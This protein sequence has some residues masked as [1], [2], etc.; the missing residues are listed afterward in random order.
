MATANKSELLRKTFT[1]E[2]WQKLEA[3]LRSG[4]EQGQPDKRWQE[5][6][7]AI[8]FSPVELLCITGAMESFAVGRY[9]L[10]RGKHDSDQVWVSAV[11]D[12][13]GSV[14]IS[15][16][17]AFTE[18]VSLLD[19]LL[20][21]DGASAPLD[22]SFEIDA[23]EL[24]ILFAFAD[25]LKAQQ[26]Q[27]LLHRE[28]YKVS[29]VT[30]EQ[31]GDSM[32]Q[33]LHVQDFRWW[34]TT[35]AVLSPFPLNMDAPTAREAVERLCQKKLLKHSGAGFLPDG[36]GNFVG[37][38]LM[39]LSAASLSLM[40]RTADGMPCGIDNVIAIRT[41]TAFW[42]LN[43]IPSPAGPAIHV[44]SSPAMLLLS[45]ID[46]LVECYKQEV[47]SQHAGKG[48]EALTQKTQ[49]RQ[50]TPDA[51]DSI[52]CPTC[53]KTLN[54]DVKFCSYCGHKMEATP[55]PKAVANSSSR[56]DFEKMAIRL[57]QLQV[58]GASS[59]EFKLI[60]ALFKGKSEDGSIWTVGLKK[61]DWFKM[62]DGKWQKSQ[63][64]ARL[65]VAPEFLA[66]LEKLGRK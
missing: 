9:H 64:P 34:V 16:P 60:H 10:L 15:F 21:F 13:N 3:G 41:S 1:A 42:V 6:F 4:T 52:V 57:R 33:G 26:L 29:P 51:C 58:S 59:E 43:L 49:A 32:H 35:G 2:E 62:V 44:V 46:K 66:A 23:H 28:A 19:G 24:G 61:P 45:Y 22:D 38:L 55:A 18:I 20:D 50:S 39:P 25:S 53:R 36:A 30:F 17:H 65:V 48:G 12:S 63:P 40:N 7:D 27:A 8:V 54:A 11:S 14:H 31:L 37:S 47:F 56:A 5:A